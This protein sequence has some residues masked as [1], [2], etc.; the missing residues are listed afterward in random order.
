MAGRLNRRPDGKRERTRRGLTRRWMLNGLA[1]V[2]LLLLIFDIAFVVVARSL[3]YQSV[4]ATL[5]LRASTY[6]RQVDRYREDIEDFRLES[7]A[8]QLVEQFTE[9]ETMELQII[10]RGGRLLA[11]STGFMPVEGAMPDYQTALSAEDHTGVYT[12][13]NST[14]ENVVA[15]TT[16]LTDDTGHPIGAMRYVA[17]LEQVDR[18]I[19]VTVLT[20]M[21]ISVGVA[22]VV[23]LA[24]RLF[25]N[26]VLRPITAISHTARR[27][28]LGDYS[29]SLRKTHDDEIG[30]LCDTINYMAGELADAERMKNEFISSVSHELRTPLTAIK[31]WSETL[32]ADPVSDPQLTTQGL[33]VI[34]REAERLSGIV[35]ELLDF[36]RM[37]SGHMAL[38]FKKT[39]L[40]AELEEVVFLYRDRA[41]REGIELNY[42]AQ[43]QSLPP[44]LGDPDRLRQV[45]INVLDNAVKYSTPP[46]LIRV[47][48]ADMG[49]R[50]Q[51]VISDSGIGIAPE[52]LAR[53]KTKFF[54]ASN[55]RPGSGIG[56]AL[57][58]EIV[59]RHGGQLDIDSEPGVGTTVTITLPTADL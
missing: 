3:T 5:R 31:G 54:R 37:Q 11:S 58:D 1:V 57:A 38:K 4:R 14:G 35:E 53:V 44:V 56:L 33:D 26:S 23:L 19:F 24:N 49:D 7:F 52:D 39:D 51:V 28:A 41:A 36:S 55:A 20:V 40:L 50:L 15:F 48:A 8:R 10:D 21:L 22:L 18:Q 29:A 43:E 59:R 42:V 9:K 12:G 16:V 47:E 17:S 25:V 45:F 27:I 32:R 30:D 2:A 13:V 6:N 34:T 46:G